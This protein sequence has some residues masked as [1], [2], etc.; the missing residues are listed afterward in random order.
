[1]IG[2]RRTRA[3][4][5]EF[6]CCCRFCL[7]RDKLLPPVHVSVRHTGSGT[8][9]PS[10][11]P[12]RGWRR[13]TLSKHTL[14]S[15][16]AAQQGS[17]FLLLFVCLWSVSFFFSFFSRI[18]SKQALKLPWLH[19]LD[20]E[21][22]E[23][24]PA[25]G[26]AGGA[27]DAAATICA[28]TAEKMNKPLHLSSKLRRFTGMS[29]LKRTALNVIANQLTEA[30]I[31]ERERRGSFG[32]AR[33]WGEREGRKG[34]EITFSAASLLSPASEAMTAEFQCLRGR[35]LSASLRAPA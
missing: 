24:E 3:E 19:A 5:G 8:I 28:T 20:D 11:P 4:T 30:D 32:A 18:M 6:F 12:V 15:T 27:G 21:A 33:P 25:D 29:N 1:M 26:A 13:T 35:R 31:G 16:A 22:Q 23:T 10:L 2:D 17:H 7:V 9:L 34:L 14:S